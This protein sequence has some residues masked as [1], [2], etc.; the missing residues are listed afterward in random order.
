MQGILHRDIKPDNCLI[1]DDDIL[2]ITDFGVSE[3]FEKGQ[4]KTDKSAGSPAFMPPEL[5]V[6]RHGEVSGRA[7]DVWSMGATLY[8]L[9]FGKIPFEKE[10]LLELYDSIRNDELKLDNND[11]EEPF[12]DL[13]FKLL[14]KDPQKRITMDEIR[15]FSVLI[16]RIYATKRIQEHP[17]VTENGANPLMSKDEN[18]AHQ[19]EPP[20]DA[21]VDAAITSNMKHL[22]TVV[23]FPVIL[24]VNFEVLRVETGQSSETI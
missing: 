1:T 10:G 18:L 9:R 14:E 3:M 6:V 11:V 8:C 7:A 12:K 19:I 16:L 15:V 4:D 17:W 23:M 24:Y 20:T 2:K 22:I 5:C 21:E 13:I